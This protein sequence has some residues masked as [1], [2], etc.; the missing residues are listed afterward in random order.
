MGSSLSCTDTLATESMCGAYRTLGDIERNHVLSIVPRMKVLEISNQDTVLALWLP[1]ECAEKVRV[2]YNNIGW[3]WFWCFWIF[4]LMLG[5]AAFFWENIPNKFITPFSIGCAI[6]YFAELQILKPRLLRLLTW[7]LEFWLLYTQSIIFC[8]TLSDLFSWNF[9]KTLFVFSGLFLGLICVVNLDAHPL[10][11]RFIIMKVTLP[12]TTGGLLFLM[13]YIEVYSGQE[14]ERRIT[15]LGMNFWN[16]SIFYTSGFTLATFLFKNVVLMWRDPSSTVIIKS[17]YR[18]T[19]Y[20]EKEGRPEPIPAS[21]NY[22]A[23][24]VSDP[25]ILVNYPRNSDNTQS[26]KTTTDSCNVP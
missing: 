21:F 6:F 8:L 15:I 4:N 18:V 24:S 19:V 25:E 14:Q 2:W 1:K 7:E 10:H 23:I 3:K 17:S 5:F 20:E 11:S 26:L 22:S 12:L 9:Y 16:R 13:L